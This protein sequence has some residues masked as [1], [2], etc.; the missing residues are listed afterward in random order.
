VNDNFISCND[1]LGRETL[2]IQ[3]DK[4]DRVEVFKGSYC[5][6]STRKRTILYQGQ[7]VGGIR[8]EPMRGD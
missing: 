8:G 3:A 6:S 4:S 5:K 2:Q 7:V 1:A